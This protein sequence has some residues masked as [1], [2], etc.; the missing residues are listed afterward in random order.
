M[1]SNIL[2]LPYYVILLYCTL[3]CPTLPYSILYATL[4]HFT[5]PRRAAPRCA[6]SH[7]GSPRPR[8]CMT[9]PTLPQFTDAN[10]KRSRGAPPPPPPPS[11]RPRW[12]GTSWP[13]SS[14]APPSAG[15]APGRRA[16]TQAEVWRCCLVTDVR[17]CSCRLPQGVVQVQQIMKLSDN[18]SSRA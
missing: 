15:S 10:P 2:Y 4:S 13:G 6:M 18:N 11:P 9:L 8:P 1:H 5:L 3:P 16:C 12:A 17:A 14:R 7:R